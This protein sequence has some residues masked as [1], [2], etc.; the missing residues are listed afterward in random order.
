MGRRRGGCLRDSLHR[1]A[2]G[3]S[4]WYDPVAEFYEGDRPQAV[5]SFS[6]P[7]A[8][9]GGPRLDDRG[10]LEA[11]LGV[12]FNDASLLR[13]ALM[14]RSYLNENAR[15][16]LLSNERLEFLGDAALGLVVA[17]RLYEL[18]PD[19]GEGLLTE[20]R[21]Y[22]VRRDTLARA[23]G[24]LGLGDAL[25]LGRGEELAGGR[26]RPSNLA[27]VFEAVVGAILIDQG[28]DAVRTVVMSA[29]GHEL[30]AVR[31][32]QVPMDPKSRLQILVQ[33]QGQDLPEYRT[34][35]AEGPDHARVFTVEVWLDGEVAGAGQ[36]RTKRQA[37]REAARRALEGLGAPS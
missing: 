16:G 35:A 21:A 27:A 20:F 36:G 19:H 28:L 32:G 34:L 13:Q 5:L 24:R 18:F 3:R 23:A 37:E 6:D 14:H 26:R 12:T 11:Q 1:C 10:D 8:E 9:C 7:V 25:L 4:G 2:G 31:S 29:L 33:A 30:E 17:Q 22:L 15:G